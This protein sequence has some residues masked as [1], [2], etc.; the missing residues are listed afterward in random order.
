M[1]PPILVVLVILIITI[2][3]IYPFPSQLLSLPFDHIFGLDSA[4]DFF[5]MFAKI[6]NIYH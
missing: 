6:T 5:F 1:D 4:I 3:K 2:T